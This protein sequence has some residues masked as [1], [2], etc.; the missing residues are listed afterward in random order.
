VVFAPWRANPRI[1]SEPQPNSGPSSPAQQV[2]EPIPSERSAPT[3][4]PPTLEAPRV[5]L[6]KSAMQPAP[7]PSE[8]HA[9]PTH[10]PDAGERQ[11]EIA[12]VREEVRTGIRALGEPSDTV[13]LTS[14]QKQLDDLLG[15]VQ[16]FPEELAP[17]GDEVR[18]LRQRL[19]EAWV[20]R[21]ARER[22]E[23]LQ[24]AGWEKRLHQIEELMVKRQFPEAESLA[25][26]LS[27]ETE[28]PET[29]AER[30]RRL[31]IQAQ[32]E[33]KKIW[34]KSKVGPTRNQVRK[35]RKPPDYLEK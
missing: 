12:R 18:G 3:P 10:L 31:A 28:A 15:L 2:L 32:S 33:L 35:S 6:P 9:P 5:S 29:V 24:A 17:E 27:Q 11:E 22:D 4:K 30:A 23:E 16:R 20:A 34:D 1:L 25:I 7:A 13:D 14:V 26:A 8:P 21:Q 19:L